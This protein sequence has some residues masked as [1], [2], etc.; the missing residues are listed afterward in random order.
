MRN[1]PFYVSLFLALVVTGCSKQAGQADADADQP[2]T[3]V[4]VALVKRQAIHSYIAA[5]A[6]LYPMKQANV[7]PKISA[8]VARFLVQRG[9]HVREGQLVAVLEHE[10]LTAAA[11]ESQ[12]LYQQAQ[13]NYQNT[14]AA[15]MPTDLTKAN[16]D[17]QS[18]REG[19]D[20]AQ[21]LYD[22]RQSLLQQGAIA[23][24]LVDDAKVSL[25]QAQSLF[26]TAQ[27]NLT[28]L[29]TVGRKEQAK[30]AQAQVEAAQ[31]HY[32]G[33]AAQVSYAEVRSPISGVVSDRPINLGEMA[34]TASALISVIDISH[35]IAHANVPVQ[36]A[37]AIKVGRP[38]TISGP[39]GE[40]SGK[41]SVVSPAVD[42][43]TTTVQ[44]WVT[45]PNPGEQ[46][47]PGA[48]V[49]ISVDAGYIPKALVIPAAA[50][51]ASDDGGEKVMIAGS[52]S[53][54]HESAVKVGVRSG[55]EVQILSG[56]QEGEQVITQGALGLDD[57]AKIEITKA[58]DA[59]DSQDEKK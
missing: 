36:Q 50:L 8:P 5:E 39:G 10:D 47:K 38:A 33:S 24:K 19:L 52:D 44:V 17:L 14:T 23:K 53:V 37:A 20:A 13:A 51:L 49:Q 2:V 29:E 32:Q 11:Q 43:N 12:D 42:P 55:E 45:A 1:F 48:T 6:I 18:A 40:L 22:N 16:S 26:Q 7:V 54:A 9:D 27:Q 25:V 3:P 41:V 30:S 4:Q 34:S 21:R 35:V 56:V 15:V 58:G 59:A 46:L 57:K 28:S 31:A